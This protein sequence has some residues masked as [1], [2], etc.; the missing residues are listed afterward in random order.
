MNDVEIKVRQLI[1]KFGRH[2]KL[3]NA[4]ELSDTLLQDLGF[5][6]LGII[7]LTTAIEKTF[8]VS[9][10]D[11]ELLMQEEWARTVGSLVIFLEDRLNMQE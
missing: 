2:S 1:V 5:D 11:E 3:P 7:Q 6:S 8:E 4:I 9:I 10:S